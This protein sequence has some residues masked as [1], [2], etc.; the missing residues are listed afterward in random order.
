MGCAKRRWAARAA[1]ALAAA[2]LAA[3]GLTGCGLDVQTPDLFLVTR[4][5]QGKPL[6]VLVTYDGGVTCNGRRGK[7]LPDRLLLLARSLPGQLESDAQK[8]LDPPSPAGSVY[9]FKVS[10]QYGTFSFPDTSAAHRPE[11]ARLEQFVLQAE[12]SCGAPG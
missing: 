5:G 8:K 4:T 11:L 10:L 7:T 6:T 9:R 2:G 3:A 1:A 12:P